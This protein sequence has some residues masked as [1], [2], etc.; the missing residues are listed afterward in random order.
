M[1]TK[2]NEVLTKGLRATLKEM[3]ANELD[4]IPGYLNE[5]EAKERLDYLL[6]IM[7]FVLPKVDKIDYSNG[8]PL[9]WD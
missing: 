1:T 4:K 3:F 7:P 5:L 8:E 9:Q 6:K 2:T